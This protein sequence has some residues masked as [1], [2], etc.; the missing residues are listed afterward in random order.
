[1]TAAPPP[2]PPQARACRAELE[3]E[4]MVGGLA[5]LR[6]LLAPHVPLYAFAVSL[7]TFDSVVG[8]TT[9]HAIS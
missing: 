7:I 8:A 2:P 9:W 6:D 4:Q 5:V 3:R 1:M